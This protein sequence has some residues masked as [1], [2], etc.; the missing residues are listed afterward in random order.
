MIN[1]YESYSS[2]MHEISM[3]KYVSNTAFHNYTLKGQTKNCDEIIKKGE[4]FLFGISPFNSRFKKKYVESVFGWATKRFKKIDILLPDIESASRL[5]IATGV[6]ESKAISKTRLELNRHK[7]YLN[8]IISDLSI[9]DNINIYDFAD[10]FTDEKYVNLVR[11][12]SE[13]YYNNDKFKIVCDDMTI[14]AVN[15]RS[16]AYNYDPVELK[17][18]LKIALPYV[19]SEIPLFTNAA[20][21]LGERSSV[22]V[23]H[24]FWP[25][26]ES[27]FNKHF[28]IS[29][30]YNQAFGVLRTA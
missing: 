10:F 21:L 12:V 7:N 22:L 14:Q 15:G 11:D 2:A 26:G 8:R 28:S 9:F 6:M 17:S 3:E 1:Y 4:H 13:L 20:N 18:I 30:A 16:K 24:K 29:V 19:I 27:L 5:L 23:Y 25:I